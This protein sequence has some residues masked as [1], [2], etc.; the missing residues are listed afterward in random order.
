M[1]NIQSETQV[2]PQI[3]SYLALIMPSVRCQG[4]PSVEHPVLGHR[5]IAF[6]DQAVTGEWNGATGQKYWL[7][8]S[9]HPEK[10]QIHFNITATENNICLVSE[11][12]N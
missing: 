11:M 4:H 7:G 10:I 8:S 12:C 3:C 5:Q 2:D 1:K 9:S 6:A